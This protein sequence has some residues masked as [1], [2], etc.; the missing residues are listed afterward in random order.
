MTVS[1]SSPVTVNEG[2][3]LTCVCTEQGSNP[4][5]TVTWYKDNKQI[6]DQGKERQ[7]LNISNVQRK[8]GGTYK[9]EAKSLFNDEKSVEIIV[10]CKH[11]KLTL[12]LSVCNFLVFVHALV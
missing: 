12:F 2:D 3:N 6:G 1:C 5:A 9:C 4:P 11:L 7:A 10:H 8:D